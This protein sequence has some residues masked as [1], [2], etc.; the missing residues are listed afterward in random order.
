M[1]ALLLKLKL[2]MSYTAASV[3]GPHSTTAS[4]CEHVCRLSCEQDHELMLGVLLHRPG[5]NW[6]D[7]D[8][9]RDSIVAYL[10]AL[11]LWVEAGGRRDILIFFISVV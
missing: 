1:T 3:A 6:L 4:E 5:C 9:A 10:Q 2:L 11:L 7:A 8:A